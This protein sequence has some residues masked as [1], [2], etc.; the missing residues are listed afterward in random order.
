MTYAY[1]TLAAL[2]TAV[3][4][5]RLAWPHL[6]SRLDRISAEDQAAIDLFL[7][8]RHETVAEAKKQIWRG[9]P[10]GRFGNIYG[11]PSRGR[12]YS[13]VALDA[14]GSRYR[15]ALAI[16]GDNTRHDLRLLQQNAEG[17]WTQVIQ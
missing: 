4:A 8:N 14:D 1:L 15:H 13:V 10:Q 17:Y 12:F 3:L 16:T 6:A 9:G 7:A 11:R 5:V 2:L